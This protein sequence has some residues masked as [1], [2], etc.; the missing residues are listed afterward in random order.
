V[1]C[2]GRVQGNFRCIEYYF[3]SCKI[4]DR[5]INCFG[6]IAVGINDM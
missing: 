2:L 6:D 1:L 5:Y 4:V 3:G